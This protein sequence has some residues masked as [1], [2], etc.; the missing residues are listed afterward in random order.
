MPGLSS[1]R[2]HSAEGQQHLHIECISVDEKIETFETNS[3]P[4]FSSSS[5]IPLPCSSL[6]CVLHLYLGERK[7]CNPGHQCQVLDWV[8]AA[9]ASYKMK[10]EEMQ[11]AVVENHTDCSNSF[12]TLQWLGFS[13]VC[14][15]THFIGI[16]CRR[17]A[18]CGRQRWRNRRTPFDGQTVLCDAWKTWT[19]LDLYIFVHTRFGSALVT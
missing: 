13:R 1:W 4:W 10:K 7:L 19:G 6:F 2:H 18:A 17:G 15:F 16:G 11:D 9:R 3:T 14:L 5:L 8:K 12:F